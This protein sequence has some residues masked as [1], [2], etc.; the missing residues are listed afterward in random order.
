M[1]GAP[2]QTDQNGIVL[3]SVGLGKVEVRVTKPGFFDATVS[4][5]ADQIAEQQLV[6]ELQPQRAEAQQITVYASRTDTRLQDLP[7]RV[8]ALDRE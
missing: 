5:S 1:N 7:L 6:I 2:K 8:E 4:L 3:I